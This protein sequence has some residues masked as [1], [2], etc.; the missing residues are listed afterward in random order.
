MITIEFKSLGHW[1]K[2]GRSSSFTE[3]RTLVAQHAP[4]GRRWMDSVRF[5]VDGRVMAYAEVCK[6]AV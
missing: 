2:A 1:R 3:A 4:L 6:E 5:V